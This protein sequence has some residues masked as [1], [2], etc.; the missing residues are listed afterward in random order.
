VAAA[1]AWSLLAG[2]DHVTPADVQAVL[3]AV[4][5]HRLQRD[6]AAL[7]AGVDGLR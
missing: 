3:P 5:E 1:R 2:R 4:A 6:A 7:L